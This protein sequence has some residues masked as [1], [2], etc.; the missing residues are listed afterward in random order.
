MNIVIVIILFREREELLLDY[1]MKY[2]EQTSRW[3][4]MLVLNAKPGG[5]IAI[6]IC[7]AP[8]QNIVTIGLFVCGQP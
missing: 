5:M 2:H 8:D 1:I 3:K 7:F 4:T 6:I